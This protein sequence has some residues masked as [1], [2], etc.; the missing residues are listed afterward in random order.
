L[1]D[2]KTYEKDNI[3]KI[4]WKK[5]GLEIKLS[6]EEN[7]IDSCSPYDENYNSK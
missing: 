2:K 7:Q 5:L 1:P 3:I 6:L 4:L